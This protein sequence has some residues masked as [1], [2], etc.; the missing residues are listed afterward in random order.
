MNERDG[1]WVCAPS[2]NTDIWN[3]EEYFD[4]KEDA[5]RAGIETIN[6]YNNG[7]NGDL[8]DIFGCDSFE[9]GENRVYSFA[10]GQIRYHFPSIDV[11]DIIEYLTQKAY[12]DCG[13]VAEDFL[14]DVS[15]NQLDILDDKLNG[16]LGDW[17]RK[18]RLYPRFYA[19]ENVEEVSLLDTQKN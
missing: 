6:K 13:E 18:F 19:I 4:T 5:I 1:K 14:S 3:A 9:F 2:T 10:V 7:V 11:D 8:D 12:F 17:L 15:Q 16:E